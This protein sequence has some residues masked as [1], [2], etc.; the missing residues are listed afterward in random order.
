MTKQQTLQAESRIQISAAE[1]SS[2]VAGFVLNFE[3]EFE[4]APIQERKLLIQRCISEIIVDRDRNIARF[5]VRRIPAVMPQM[6]VPSQKRRVPTE[7]VSTRS[8]GGANI[9]ILTT[10]L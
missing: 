6:Q 3:R 9:Q 5:H 7:V 1:I 4:K 2:Q 8:S 10:P